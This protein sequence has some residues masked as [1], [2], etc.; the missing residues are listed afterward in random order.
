M[1]PGGQLLSGGQRQ[2]ACLARALLAQAPV[3]MFDE[4]TASLD[5]LSAR[6]V[7]DSLV[8]LRAQRTRIVVT[9]QP[10]LAAAA[11]T[12]VVLDGGR[13]RAT[14][15]HAQL[16]EADA[17]YATFARAGHP[18]DGAPPAGADADEATR[19]AESEY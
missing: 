5:A 14:G 19:P 3:L 2:R 7:R 10:A 16:V 18:L 11:D 6:R 13:V 15:T 8:A 9:H 17:W 4:P 12:I 1:G